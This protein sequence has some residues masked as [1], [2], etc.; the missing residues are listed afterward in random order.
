MALLLLVLLLT[1]CCVNCSQNLS[2]LFLTSASSEF[3]TSGVISAVDLA[4]KDILQKSFFLD[5][6]TL[7]YTTA[8][9]SRVQL[10]LLTLVRDLFF[11]ATVTI[12]SKY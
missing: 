8:I 5:G 7:Q 10:N 9:D 3:N 4:L 1:V 12:H 6:Y 2:F 11:S